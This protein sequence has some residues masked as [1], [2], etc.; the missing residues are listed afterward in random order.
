MAPLV[1][2]VTKFGWRWPSSFSRF[3]QWGTSMDSSPKAGK[4]QEEEE[5]EGGDDHHQE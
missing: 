1:P 2:E 3:F 4:R 5:E